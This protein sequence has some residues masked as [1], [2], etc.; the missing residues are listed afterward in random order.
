[1]RVD[2]RHALTILAVIGIA[3]SF[4]A[5]AGLQ[6]EQY[7][8]CSYD[9]VWDAAVDTMKDRPVAR[10]DKGSGVIETAWTE[11]AVNGRGFGAFG[12]DMFDSKERARLSLEVKRLNEVTKVSVSE[13]RERWHARGGVTQQAVKWSPVEP[14]QEAMTTVMGQLNTRVSQQGCRVP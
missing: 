14:S 1:M 11:M 9:T 3:I 7:F 8:V 2:V 13:N 12:R 6:R 10:K 5:C 4:T